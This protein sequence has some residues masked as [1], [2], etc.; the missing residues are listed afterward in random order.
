M[1][2]SETVNSVY[3]TTSE[4]SFL[5]LVKNALSRLVQR[6]QGTNAV[7]T[8]GDRALVVPYS[9]NGGTLPEAAKQLPPAHRLRLELFPVGTPWWQSVGSVGVHALCGRLPA[10]GGAY[11]LSGRLHRAWD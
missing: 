5:V 7:N 9:S 3:D 11:P 8:G 2:V 1:E 6:S 10:L 4:L